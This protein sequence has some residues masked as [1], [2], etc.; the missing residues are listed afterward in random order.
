MTAAIRD[1]TEAGA[2]IMLNLFVDESH[3][4]FP[5]PGDAPRIV[6]V[7]HQPSE[8]A[9]DI[10]GTGPHRD[11]D[12]VV[13]LRRTAPDALFVVHTKAAYDDAVTSTYDRHLARIVARVTG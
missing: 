2:E 6:Q 7:L 9:D 12:M 3:E 13:S 4:S 8:L 10:V 5:V 1:A 11:R